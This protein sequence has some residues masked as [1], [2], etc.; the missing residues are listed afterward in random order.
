MMFHKRQKPQLL[1]VKHAV[2]YS[3]HKKLLFML[4]CTTGPVLGQVLAR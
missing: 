2:F 3:E 4:L 1:I